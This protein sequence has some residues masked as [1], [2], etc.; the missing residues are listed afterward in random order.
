MKYKLLNSIK[1]RLSLTKQNLTSV[2]SGKIEYDG[3]RLILKINGIPS[4]VIIQYTGVVY[5]N[6]AMSPLINVRF[7][8]NAIYIFNFFRKPFPEMIFDYSGDLKITNCRIMSFDQSF[9]SPTIED[10][11][12][13]DKAEESKTNLEDDDMILF[14]ENMKPS[15]IRTLRGSSKPN[16]LEKKFD[17][18][19]AFQKYGKAEVESI[20]TAVRSVVKKSLIKSSLYKK[21]VS[22]PLISKTG[23]SKPIVSKSGVSKPTVTKPTVSKPT[24]SSPKIEERKGGKY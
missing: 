14:G 15:N 2:T 21:S 12:G 16:I 24:I 1:K 18:Y 11:I 22:K 5:F 6:S 3:Y 8:K 9:F 7:N 23:V 19:G 13:E 4:S 17:E 20:A 10:K